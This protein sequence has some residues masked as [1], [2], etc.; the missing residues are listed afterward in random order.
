MQLPRPGLR[1]QLFFE[2]GT[3]ARDTRR[4]D[5]PIDRHIETKFALSRTNIARLARAMSVNRDP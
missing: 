4:R 1:A 5:R 3:G 2:I